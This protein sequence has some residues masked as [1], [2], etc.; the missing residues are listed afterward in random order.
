MQRKRRYFAVGVCAVATLVSAG[1]ERSTDTQ[2]PA[3][4]AGEIAQYREPMAA[5]PR[6][7]ASRTAALT[8]DRAALDAQMFALQAEQRALQLEHDRL[9]QQV[10][11][12]QAEGAK[13]L[14]Q[15]KSQWQ[16]FNGKP[17]GQS[18]DVSSRER[19]AEQARVE[20]ESALMMDQDYRARLAE[21][22]NKLQAMEQKL[23]SLRRE[24]TEVSASHSSE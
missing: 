11:S 7:D 10:E 2:R 22:E 8:T 12:H 3:K 15:L 23:Q 19:F 6:S 21:T 13:K 9:A 24:Q 4:T 16:S 14:A 1:C 18:G 20:M 5:A 17:S